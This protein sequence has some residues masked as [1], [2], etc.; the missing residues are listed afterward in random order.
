MSGLLELVGLVG[1]VGLDGSKV[2][3]NEDNFLKKLSSNYRSE[4]SYDIKN[5]K[6]AKHTNCSRYIK[7]KL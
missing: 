4:N 5:S 3:I 7:I 6:Q 1:L 2:D